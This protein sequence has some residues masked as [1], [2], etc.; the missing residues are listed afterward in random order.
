MILLTLLNQKGYFKLTDSILLLFYFSTCQ[1][2]V[3]FCSKSFSVLNYTVVICLRRNQ[4]LFKVNSSEQY[5]PTK[6]LQHISLRGFLCVLFGFVVLFFTMETQS[7]QRV[8]PYFPQVDKQ[9]C[10][11]FFYP[12]EIGFYIFTFLLDYTH[13]THTW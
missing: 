7:A 5:D 2:S 8:F 12:P 13:L 11:T 1:S 6:Y 4:C 9:V 10:G 3:L